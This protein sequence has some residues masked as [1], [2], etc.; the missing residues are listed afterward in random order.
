[1]VRVPPGHHG[2]P[3]SIASSHT[4]HLPFHIQQSRCSPCQNYYRQAARPREAPTFVGTLPARMAADRDYR[5][6]GFEPTQHIVTSYSATLLRMFHCRFRGWIRLYSSS[7][8]AR[9]TGS[10]CDAEWRRYAT[11]ALCTMKRHTITWEIAHP[12]SQN[13]I[14][15]RRQVA[16]M[17]GC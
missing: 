7:F 13:N 12:G 4:A 2:S 1:M 15:Y 14:R 9:W 17:V 10:I 16:V 11:L 8:Y 6:V 3:A 5:N